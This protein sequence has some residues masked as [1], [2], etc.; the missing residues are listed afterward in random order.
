MC[1]GYA[2]LAGNDYM[3]MA[4][5]F[6]PAKAFKALSYLVEN[7]DLKGNPASLYNPEMLLAA[8][9]HVAPENIEISNA[10]AIEMAGAL[11]AFLK[12][13]VY[14]LASDPGQRTIRPLDGSQW[15]ENLRALGE[16]EMDAEKSL[17]LALGI[18]CRRNGCEV[19]KDVHARHSFEEDNEDHD[20]RVTS[21]IVPG[22][23]M[24][25]RTKLT[26]DILPGS[27]LSAEEIERATGDM[28]KRWLRCRGEP[29]TGNLAEL[30]NFVRI[31]Y[32]HEHETH[33]VDLIC[34]DARSLIEYLIQ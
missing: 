8:A 10:S 25:N 9:R 28:L 15:S 5:G 32:K 29:T 14:F 33:E 2:L 19:C 7:Y 1:L 13:L 4:K 30:R 18:R 27:Y 23:A 34:P 12:G 22:D 21:F 3:K 26:Y 31:G 16:P 6:G 17:L 11:A 24:G 20:D